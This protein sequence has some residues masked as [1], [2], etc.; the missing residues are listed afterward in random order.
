M[1]KMI[2]LNAENKNEKDS[3]AHLDNFL[4]F[5]I[6]CV[7]KNIK[8][9]R[10]KNGYL[11]A[12]ISDRKGESCP[13]N[14]SKETKKIYREILVLEQT[15]TETQISY[16]Q[17]T[18][19]IVEHIKFD[20]ESLYLLAK[21]NTDLI[22]KLVIDDEVVSHVIS[23]FSVTE[24]KKKF[25]GEVVALDYLSKKIISMKAL[26]KK[27]VQEEKQ[28]VNVIT[29]TQDEKEKQLEFD[30]KIADIM[31]AKELPFAK[32]AEEIIDSF[33]SLVPNKFTEMTE[34]LSQKILKTLMLSVD[35]KTFH[36][37][38][39]TYIFSKV[40]EKKSRYL[41]LSTP[42]L[43]MPS[44]RESKTVELGLPPSLIDFSKP[45]MTVNEF[46]NGNE[47]LS[48]ASQCL[49]MTIFQY[50]PIHILN[51]VDE[52]LENIKVYMTDMM[53]VSGVNP[54]FVPFDDTFL[55]FSAV[56]STSDIASFQAITTICCD[57]IREKMLPNN[58][59]FAQM[60]LKSA[61][62]YQQKQKGNVKT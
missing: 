8:T 38:F 17:H 16:N 57:Y 6:K 22:P 51:M 12:S 7:E 50:S 26:F 20:F 30:E 10:E 40:Y 60:M 29:E 32:E 37:A 54:G 1:T 5:S 48:K 61:M 52:A 34:S 18:V 15:K 2:D 35:I 43:F 41:Q 53:T 14:V 11:I 36:S 21:I 25:N 62:E 49:F 45:M 4:D 47:A 3:E 55:L 33:E 58:L 31:E 39:I 42:S 27:K 44:F 13:R 46:V 24:E 23:E 59:A 19:S 28:Q 56:L 9:L